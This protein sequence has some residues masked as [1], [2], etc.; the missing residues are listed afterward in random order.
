MQARDLP[1]TTLKNRR[2]S[3]KAWN[4][5]YTCLLGVATSKQGFSRRA[6]RKDTRRLQE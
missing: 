2:E 5:P 4:Y 6:Q 3:R 1:Y